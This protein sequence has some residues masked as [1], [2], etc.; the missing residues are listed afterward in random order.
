MMAKGQQ[1]QGHSNEQ[2]GLDHINLRSSNANRG[3]CTGFRPGTTQRINGR[4]ALV[5]AVNGT[6]T[7]GTTFQL[8]RMPV[9]IRCLFCHVAFPFFGAPRLSIRLRSKS[10]SEKS[11]L[12]GAVN[13]LQWSAFYKYHVLNDSPDGYPASCPL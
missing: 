7:Q 2:E 1:G 8:D 6:D 4:S 9:D 3:C 11:T 13:R 10:K 12:S 5:K